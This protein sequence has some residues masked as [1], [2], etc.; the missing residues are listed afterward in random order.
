MDALLNSCPPV[1]FAALEE[2]ILSTALVNDN[3]LFYRTGYPEYPLYETETKCW[4]FYCTACHM[5]M[6]E[7]KRRKFSPKDLNV[8]PECGACVKPKRWIQHRSRLNT[9][10]LYLFFQRGEGRQVWLQAYAV[11]HDFCPGPG[12]ERLEFFEMSRYLFEDGRAHK[13]SQSMAYFGRNLPAGWTKRVRA[14]NTVWHK[15][16]MSCD[17]PYPTF[18]GPIEP[19]LLRGS[20]LE[21]SQLDQAAE[22]RFDLPEYL[23]FYLKNPMI[24]YLWKFR[25]EHLLW[26]GLMQGQRALFRTVI[27]LRAK[28]PKD[29]LRGLTPAEGRAIAEREDGRRTVRLYQ[30]MKADGIVHG[31]PQCWAW[32]RATVDCESTLDAAAGRGVG[33]KALRT[34]IERQAKRSGRAMRTILFDYRDY[35]Q[36][37]E[38]TGGGELLPDDLQEA[39]ERLSLRLR[40]TADIRLNSCFRHRRRLYRWLCWRHGGLVIRA[41]DSMQEITAEGERQ[42]NCVAGYAKRHANGQTIICVLRQA[43]KPGTSWHTVE[44]DP[45]TLEVIQCRSFRNGEA[46][47]EAQ[48]F[49]H[50]WV[51]RLKYKKHKETGGAA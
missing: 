3:Y 14:T 31:S 11:T 46:E 12:D 34:Y 37:L 28:H 35:L 25:L 13:W 1:D 27:N 30:Q 47:P 19:G 26:E 21:Y 38:E 22:L 7:G 29:L 15:N 49:I 8:C 6:Y 44:L 39:H 10:I 16:T 41:V 24:E 50:A 43:K 33:G 18:F 4:E 2:D 20:C 45:G 17:T 32:V 9:K 42:R 51:Q 40:Q 5:G 36:Q 23:D 48:A